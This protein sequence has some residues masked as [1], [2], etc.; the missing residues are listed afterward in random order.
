[1]RGQE[2]AQNGVRFEA[3]RIGLALVTVAAL[4]RV[5][6]QAELSAADGSACALH[7]EASDGETAVVGSAVA[8]LTTVRLEMMPAFI[9]EATQGYLLKAP[10]Q[11]AAAAAPLTDATGLKKTDIALAEG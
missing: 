7:T 5:T 3:V 1:V 10:S 6:S 4:V 9:A 11:F 8:V 2:N